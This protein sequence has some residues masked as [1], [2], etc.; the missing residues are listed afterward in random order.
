VDD[1]RVPS[2]T[3]LAASDDE[4]SWAVIEP[5]YAAVNIY[6][7]PAVLAET[8]RP[9]T[10]G[11]RALLAVHW[12]VSEVM[13]GGI[14][15]FLTNPTGVLADEAIAAFRLI[16]VPEAAAALT[17]G[18]SMVA[19]TPML[20]DPEAPDYNELEAEEAVDALRDRLAPLDDRIYELLDEVIYPRAAA[21]VRT[22][23][24][25]FVR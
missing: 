10:R 8:M 6:D 15:Q 12:C 5:A 11:Q 9:L 2:S 1:L 4:L 24:E 20:A 23:P 13:N 25:E 3:L 7:G 16:G 19:A 22:H 21:Y 18:I 17:D 14:H